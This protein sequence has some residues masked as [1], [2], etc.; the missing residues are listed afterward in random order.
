MRE[1]LWFERKARNS[2]GRTCRLGK[3]MWILNAMS[4]RGGCEERNNLL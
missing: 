2:S 3:A 4:G 1:E